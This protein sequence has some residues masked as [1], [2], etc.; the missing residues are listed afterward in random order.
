VTDAAVTIIGILI[1]ATLAL[2]A[3]GT[4]GYL[5]LMVLLYR[6]MK[7][8]DSRAR[9]TLFEADSYTWA[10]WLSDYLWEERYHD[11]HDERF[12]VL[13]HRTRRLRQGVYLAWALFAGLVVLAFTLHVSQST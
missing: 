5:A 4:F 11:S 9:L 12:K 1:G 3:F 10:K 7:T 13:C 8:G 6:R 2:I